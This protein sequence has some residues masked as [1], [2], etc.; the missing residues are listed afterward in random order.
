M[1]NLPIEL[2]WNIMKFMRHPIADVVQDVVMEAYAHDMYMKEWD[3]NYEL[4]RQP[5]NAFIQ[6]KYQKRL[7]NLSAYSLYDFFKQDKYRLQ[8]YDNS[9]KQK[10]IT[11]KILSKFYIQSQVVDHSFFLCKFT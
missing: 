9:K 2:Q 3:I 6:A 8:F 1:E 11:S 7:K 10:K 4:N 5:N